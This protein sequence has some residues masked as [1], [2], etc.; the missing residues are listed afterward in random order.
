M[1]CYAEYDNYIQTNAKFDNREKIFG[2]IEI[3]HFANVVSLLCIF[4]N[5][6]MIRYGH[7]FGMY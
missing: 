4:S 6:S 5:F 3:I 1:L 7:C 2:K